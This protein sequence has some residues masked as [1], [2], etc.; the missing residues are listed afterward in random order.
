MGKVIGLLCKPCFRLID[1]RGIAPSFPLQIHGIAAVQDIK[2]HDL[3]YARYVRQALLHLV[4]I[5]GEVG[6]NENFFK[7]GF[8]SLR[9][10]TLKYINLV[11]FYKY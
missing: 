10:S 8:S 2:K 4:G 1:K 3:F 6:G 11:M 5:A 7:H 9:P